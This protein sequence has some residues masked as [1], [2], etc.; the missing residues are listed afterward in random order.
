MILGRNI[1]SNELKEL[2]RETSVYKYYVELKKDVLTEQ[3]FFD[4]TKV[5]GLRVSGAG[6]FLKNL[7]L[8]KRFTQPDIAKIFKVSRSQV[9]H[10]EH[11]YR[12]ISLRMLVDIAES[13]DVP[14]E[15]IYSLIDQGTFSLKTKLP[16]ELKKIRNLIQYFSP[17]KTGVT[18]QTTVSKC[19]NET[20]SKIRA[21][22]NLKIHSRPYGLRIYSK[23]LYNFLKTFFRY[24]KILK[25][26]PPLTNEVKCWY[27][28]SIDLKRAVII[29]FLQSDGSIQTQSH[30][31]RLHGKNQILHN[32]FVDAM[33]YEYDE[34]PTSYFIPESSNSQSACY[35]T[36]YQRKTAKEIIDEVMKLAGNS[37]TKPANRQEVEE[38]LKESQPHLG[39]LLKAPES[40]QRIALR[41]WASTECCISLNRNEKGYITPTF[42]IACA[43]PDLNAQLKQI[44]EKHGI[45]LYEQS[46][47][48][49]WSGIDSLTSAT[50][51]TCLNFLKLGGFIERVKISANSPYHEGIDKNL[52]T[53]GILEFMKRQKTNQE[54][55]KLSLEKVH[56]EINNIIKNKQ[57]KTET[58]YIN[59]FS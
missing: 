32:Y 27:H 3:G 41:I 11:D 28:N 42:K 21:V 39:Y 20:L 45:L 51:S 34:L 49:I 57:Y 19:S 13:N 16:I 52:L 35:S 8:E 1:G 56:H 5:P 22:L 18:W 47:P 55:R 4:L 48:T 33:Y 30:K 37:K 25:I 40:E 59:Y 44:A 31:I 50:T 17:H 53:L 36:E 54:L 6:Q 15:T 46:C 12:T 7:R 14:R 58:Y 9:N 24:I 26:H 10:W 43:H 38:Y 2:I 29:P 23:D